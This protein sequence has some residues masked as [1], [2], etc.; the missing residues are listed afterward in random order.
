MTTTSLMIFDFD[1]M[2]FDTHSSIE[3]T[4]SLTFASLLPSTPPLA[5][6]DIRRLISSGPGIADT[7]RAL[8]PS[9]AALEQD[10]GS[11][12]TAG[13]T[14]S[15]TTNRSSGPS[16]A[17]TSKGVQA[18]HAALRNNGLNGYVL[19]DLIVGDETPGATRKP[20]VGSFTDVLV[21]KMREAGLA[22]AV[23]DA[24]KV[25]VAGDRVADIQFARNI[26]ARACWAQYGYGERFKY[27]ELR[28]DITIEKLMDVITII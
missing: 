13:C 24:S 3:E 23:L 20:D 19:E 7:F 12:S 2:F 21:P 10:P 28:P 8:H 6:A 22:D 17:P 9:P 27:E 18:V 11:P 26:G 16:P 15:S 1:G 4:I 5:P 14:P 25:V